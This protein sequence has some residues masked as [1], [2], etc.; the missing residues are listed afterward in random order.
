MSKAKKKKWWQNLIIA[1]C[2][3]ILAIL[4]ILGGYVAYLSIQFYRIEDN[5]E[6]VI[7]N[8]QTTKISLGQSYKIMTY[9]IGFGAYSQDF[10]FFMDKGETLDGTVINGTGSRAKDKDTV[11]FN[12]NGAI[13]TASNGAYDF[14]FFQEVDTKA[15]RSHCVNQFQMIADSFSNYANTFA[16]NF[17]SGYLFYP[18]T[19]PHGSVNAGIAT[20]SKYQITSSTRRSLPIDM[21]FFSKFFDLDRCF[22]VSRL[23]IEGSNKEL[24]LINLHLSAYD[25][26]GKIRAKQLEMLNSVLAA[27]YA[28]GNYIIAGGDFNHDIADSLHTFQTNRKVPEW[29]QVLPA[30]ALIDH[31]SFASSNTI[32]TCRS[33]DGPYVKGESYT[34]VLDGYIVS[35]NV[36]VSS[37]ANIDTDF[38]YSD[39]N[40]A[41]MTFV[42][43]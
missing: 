5:Q 19:N 20:L 7:N 23:P 38:M 31:F 33:T 25:E 1:I 11:L 40:P 32:P 26:G 14:M 29:T 12:T 27:E 37:V 42:L 4:L 30:D 39:H 6:L 41:T 3:I 18:I 43:S 8:N 9:N 13:T 16:S 21:G 10:S 17:H 35:D 2:S 34:V 22:S 36:T 28:A 24:V 15:Q